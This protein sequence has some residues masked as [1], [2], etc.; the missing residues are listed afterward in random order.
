MSCAAHGRAFLFLVSLLLLAAAPE[1]GAQDPTNVTL[2]LSS[3]SIVENGG[4]TRLTVTLSGPAT[5][6]DTTVNV[7]EDPEFYT[8]DAASRTIPAGSTSAT[9]TITA[10][11]DAVHNGNRVVDIFVE[12]LGGPS[13]DVVA[14]DPDFVT[15]TI[16]D[17]ESQPRVTLSVSPNPINEGSL[18]NEA[19]VTAS[20]NNASA[21][22]IRVTV[23]A[24][25]GSAE[26]EDFF[27]SGSDLFITAGDTTS[28][29][30]VTIFAQ[31]DEDTA[32]ETVT[33]SGTVSDGTATAPS[34]VTLNIRDND[35]RGVSISTPRLTV[36]EGSTNQ[37]SLRLNTKP[38]SAVTLTFTAAAGVSVD[39]DSF[40][41]SEQ[42]SLTITPEAWDS[43]FTI[44]VKGSQ[45]A[46]AADET[47]VRITHGASGGGYNGISIPA[48]EVT[49]TDDDLA[50]IT[51]S[52][53]DLTVNETG[54]GRYTVRLDTPPSAGIVR[55]NVASDNA[56][57]T[58]NPTSL[59]FNDRN[60]YDPQGVTVTAGDD[61]DQRERTATIRHAINTRST[62]APEYDALTDL[63]ED[64]VMV[65]VVDDDGGQPGVTVSKTSLAVDEGRTAN[66]TLRLNSAP[67]QNVTI[68]PASADETVATVAPASLT[69]TPANWESAQTVTVT[70][71]Q[72]PDAGDSTA[73]VSHTTTSSD[74]TW[75]NIDLFF[76][77][78]T[79]TVEDDDIAQITV[80][81]NPNTAGVQ[82]APVAVTEGGTA[83][84]EVALSHPPTA[85]VQIDLTL[86]GDIGF[87]GVAA[88]PLG[89]V[90]GPDDWAPKTVT[91]LAG[92]DDLDSDN[93][94]AT[95][96]HSV[97]VDATDRAREYDQVTV[98]DVSVRV[99]DNDQPGATVTEIFEAIPEGGSTTYGVR[100]NALPTGTVRLNIRSDN[101]DVTVDPTMLD[102]DAGNWNLEQSVT[103]NAAHDDDAANDSATISHAID[104]SSSRTTAS[105]YRSV[106]NL[107][108]VP[109]TV[110]DDETAG[111]TVS[112]PTL[113]VAESGEGRY[114]VRLDTRPS[115]GNVVVT[116]AS[117]NTDVRATPT[118]LTFTTGNWNTPRA[119]T[120]R[121]ANDTDQTD[122]TATLSHTI[123]TGSTTAPEYD[124]LTDLSGANVA[125]T[126]I[127]NDVVGVTVSK[128]GLAIDEG[129]NATYT[130]RLNTQ[131]T[132]NVTITPVAD[133]ATAVRITPAV[134][135]F[136]PSNG[137][138]AQTVRVTGAHDDDAVDETATIFH[139]AA[140]GD[141]NYN[142]I[143]L[144]YADVAVSVDDDEPIP[145]VKLTV[146][147]DQINEGDVGNTAIVTA[148]LNQA[149]SEDVT[150]TVA[151]TPLNSNT[152]AEDF[153]GGSGDIF[154]AAGVT[155]SSDQVSIF[156]QDDEDNTDESVRITGTV[157]GGVNPPV[158][159]TLRIRDNDRPGVAV[160]PRTLTVPEGGSGQYELTLFTRPTGNVTI[161]ATPARA[162]VT[163]DVALFTDGE[164]MSRTITPEEWDGPLWSRR[165][166]RDGRR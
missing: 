65:T 59:T 120:V 80:D 142:G 114:T 70:G 5:V 108:S 155:T 86:S 122:D 134:L 72:D 19:T 64:N 152:A 17:N 37:Y 145:T 117:D 96:A 11:D 99:Q 95:I 53:T 20:L 22:D 40:E 81:T 61:M 76:Q 33:I 92:E 111:V 150:V 38:S 119:V 1:A 18:G 91:V 82:T 143:D 66:Y 163:V 154:I 47:G 48:V 135:T 35:V 29:G 110:D 42:T 156:S 32:S 49:V 23:T 16:R 100:L 146:T 157:T 124:A 166:Q 10:V 74:L 138:T 36:D 63:S 60:W 57:V 118:S 12:V 98:A 147:P 127:D 93:D 149:W 43:E 24:A 88:D 153:T 90:F 151:A 25:G 106:R 46:D 123:N 104:T 131:P 62:G 15:L 129:Q 54:S 67:E 45:D 41:F 125:V 78:V 128:T 2:G 6:D 105:E 87:E 89:L 144:G 34:N 30:D 97:N 112:A 107:P 103:V 115:T 26:E 116:V 28:P 160:S 79:V 109:V 94:M 31:E 7:L 136:T 8:L 85:L 44:E 73:V 139:T 161:R 101:A 75:D 141:G 4:T 51:V 55:V 14:P 77:D 140:S 102:F 50:G 132:A 162:E 71:E 84:Y 164:Q 27:V 83:T 121:A 52:P 137:T 113:T 126:V 165:S 39:A 158:P 159:T 133:D 68:T 58:V 56:E 130:L 3:A 21:N 148:S 9:F 69:F 13:D